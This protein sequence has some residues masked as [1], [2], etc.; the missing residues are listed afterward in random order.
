MLLKMHQNLKM[1]PFMSK[2][3]TLLCASLIKFDREEISKES[4]KEKMSAQKP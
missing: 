2:A 1:I 4:V 3:Y